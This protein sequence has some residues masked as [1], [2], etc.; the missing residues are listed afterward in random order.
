MNWRR[1]VRLVAA[2]AGLGCAVALFLLYK[3]REK[4]PP[5]GPVPASL[6][7]D[8]K[9]QSQKGTM[10]YNKGT[11]SELSLAY[12]ATKTYA[13]GRSVF[14]KGHVVFENGK[15][16][17]WA[18]VI[19][20]QGSNNPTAKPTV[21]KMTGAV[22]FVGRDGLTL[23]VDNATYDDATGIVTMPGA[24]KFTR[25]RLTGQSVGGFYSRADEK[26][27]L[28]DQAVA[29]IVADDKGAGGVALTSKSMIMLPAQHAIHLEQNARV[30]T[31]RQTLTADNAVIVFTDD[32]QAMKFLELRG[33][34][35]VTP[36]DAVK[37]R[38]TDMKGDNIT[39]AFHPDGGAVQH[40]T[41]TGQARLGIADEGGRRAIAGSWIDL[42]TAPDGRTLVRLEARD[43]VEVE[44]PPTKEAPARVIRGATL[45][46]RGEEKTGLQSAI[47]DGGVT[48]EERDPGGRGKAP[49][50]R[51]GKSQ[52]LA[53]KLAGELEAVTE[54]EFRRSFTF[55]DGSATAHAEHGKYD[56]KV[57]SLDLFV[58][59]ANPKRLPRVEDEGFE[60]EGRT[61]K[62]LTK[63]TSAGKTHDIQARGTVT[64]RMLPKKDGKRS[65]SLFDDDREIY[66]SADD[67]T[68]ASA[69]KQAI[70]TGTD[71]TPAILLQD[72]NRISA[73]RVALNEGS[74]NLEASGNVDS[75]FVSTPVNSTDKNARMNRI[76]G[77]S[78]QFD[79]AKR[80]ATYIGKPAVL[81][82][83]DA[84]IEGNRLVLV[85]AAEGRA[86]QSLTAVGNMIGALKDGN[87]FRG[88]SL[89]FDANAD[90]YVI[91]GAPARAKSAKDQDGTCKLQRADRIDFSGK[92]GSFN[93]TG[94]IRESTNI[95]CAISIRD[96]K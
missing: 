53:L 67:V 86:I 13:D 18:D 26:I 10:I 3:P 87:E 82:G 43:N 52:S 7:P 78:M 89:T 63:D 57:G 90:Q 65:S 42:F 23:N 47:F 50:T 70:Y 91:S 9:W 35:T 34:A 71:D 22:R 40:A 37:D 17:L 92:S 4:E 27:R 72:K 74:G 8:A 69:D 95:D 1:A 73:R 6:D 76:T 44:L 16:E 75:S 77:D 79:D 30:G 14:D 56:V 85:M 83:D 48:F 33:R 54:A 81:K 51:T 49:V 41:V 58:D 29:N 45:A 94:A 88:T 11:G 64:T 5:P 24:L 2:L 96:V 39:L 80:Q 12:E 20:T 25:G 38:R 68:Y 46:A 62:L 93:A 19:E 84:T 66:G 36:T 61:V 59:P 31:D 28:E 32:E 21:F 60:L 15:Y 55:E